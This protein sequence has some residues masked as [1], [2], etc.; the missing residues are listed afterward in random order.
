MNARRVGTR[1]GPSGAPGINLLAGRAPAQARGQ[2]RVLPDL[3][4][5]YR[6]QPLLAEALSIHLRYLTPT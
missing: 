2:R 3:I 6:S 5:L 4:G 1:A